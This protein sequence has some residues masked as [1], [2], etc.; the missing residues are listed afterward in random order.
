MNKNTRIYDRET[1][2]IT[3]V[4]YPDRADRFERDDDVRSQRFNPRET[5][6]KHARE[7]VPNSFD[8]TDSCNERIDH[9]TKA[10]LATVGQS[11]DGQLGVL[12]DEMLAIKLAVL[13]LSTLAADLTSR[14]D[15]IKAGLVDRLRDAFTESIKSGE[16]YRI[17]LLRD[18]RPPQYGS[19]EPM[20]ILLALT[21]LFEGATNAV[22]LRPYL[23]DGLAQGLYVSFAMSLANVSFGVL[24]TFYGLRYWFHGA[25]PK[26]RLGATV[27]IVCAAAGVLLNWGFAHFRNALEKG[28]EPSAI[29]FV[30]LMLP[31]GGDR[32]SLSAAALFLI[33]VLCFAF[34]ALKGYG[35]KHSAF[36]PRPGLTA[37]HQRM[38]CAKAALEPL[39]QQFRERVQSELQTFCQQNIRNLRAQDN[40]KL[41]AMS[42]LRDAAVQ[43]DHERRETAEELV[44]ANNRQRRIYRETQMFIRG[45]EFVPPAY[46]SVY[47]DYRETIAAFPDARRH[48][49]LFAE[50]E[51]VY[52]QNAENLTLAEQKL[53][54]QMSIEV[55]K[56]FKELAKLREAGL[57]EYARSLKPV[58]PLDPPG[59]RR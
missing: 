19:V 35:G 45:A 48:E 28:A 37:I 13:H 33:G 26:R 9:D 16:E 7:G 34:A 29:D 46:F 3:S 41:K 20:A 31:W 56:T 5:A 27:A 50:A 32:L 40:A 10:H 36:D 21:I 1:G 11:T 2:N 15:L 49:R 17:A 38:V 54:E 55:T 58:L 14:I 30:A 57:Q 47:P 8:T 43:V 24:S 25:G 22:Y 52:A 12:Y 23:T 53:F 4:Q 6:V 44:E 18:P 42:E 51:H 39:K 59:G